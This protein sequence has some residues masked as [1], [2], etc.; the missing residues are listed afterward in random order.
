MTYSSQLRRARADANLTP[1]LQEMAQLD[2]KAHSPH[3][4]LLSRL[5]GKIDEMVGPLNDLSKRM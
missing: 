5:G 4:P 1:I 3:T 2:Q